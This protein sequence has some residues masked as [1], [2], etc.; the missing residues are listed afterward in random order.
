MADPQ[1]RRSQNES[2]LSR[3]RAF[4][5]SLLSVSKKELDEAIEVEKN[6][7]ERSAEPDAD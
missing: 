4:L 1:S 6:E 3:F 2:T 7:K 5:K